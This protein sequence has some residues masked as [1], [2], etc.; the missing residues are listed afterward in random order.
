MEYK[1]SFVVF[2]D[3]LGFKNMVKGKRYADIE[4]YLNIVKREIL[5]LK[6]I[7]LKKNIKSIVIS[8]SIILSID[9]VD[10]NSEDLIIL[11]N[12]C[13]FVAKIQEKLALENIWMRGAI[14]HGETH[15]DEDNNQVVGE[16]YI[17]AYLL[18]ESKAIYPRV[19]L[20]NRI[21]NFLKCDSAADL[22]NKINTH[23]YDNWTGNILYKWENE[24]THVSAQNMVFGIKKDIPLFIDYLD[25][26]K[27]N[28][29]LSTIVENLKKSAYSSTNVYD[30]H[31][32][33]ASYLISKGGFGKDAE[34]ANQLKDI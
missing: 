15:F 3:V 13:L 12:L 25:N 11:Q 22:I 34:I 7:D 1:K 16:A 24:L 26:L 9:T 32:W 18:E 4:N 10:D 5:S 6:E 19:I 17:D 8:D 2:L 31:K 14:S 28:N 30:K 33:T 23:S 29:E 21:I 20:D 27:K